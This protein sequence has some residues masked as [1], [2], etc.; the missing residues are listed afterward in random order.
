VESPHHTPIWKTH[1]YLLLMIYL[2]PK[3]L[4]LA[5]CNAHFIF[6]TNKLCCF[7]TDLV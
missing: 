6:K 7:D 3:R 1:F 4:S 2:L 5:S